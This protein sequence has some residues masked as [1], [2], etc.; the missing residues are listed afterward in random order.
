MIRSTARDATQPADADHPDG[1][2][3]GRTPVEVVVIANE[4]LPGRAKTRL[5]PPYTTTEAAALA[6]A[7][8]SDTL[9]AV[10]RTPGVRRAIAFAGTR[11]DWLPA[12]FTAIPQRGEGLDER[13]AAAFA[14]VHVRT[15]G[16]VVIIGMD[17]PQVT[18]ALLGDAA[19]RLAHGCADAVFGPADDGGYWLLGL[20]VPDPGFVR[21]VPMSRPDTGVAQLARL[22]DARLRV[23]RMPRLR[24]VDTYA[25]AVR[26]ARQAPH[27]EFAAR[28]RAIAADVQARLSQG[29][30]L[31]AAH[32]P[33]D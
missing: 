24:D 3:G 6:E 5:S 19:G 8:L 22:R 15:G 23:H 26:V 10:S 31:T 14:D 32:A 12:G 20:R 2:T 28:V 4:P 1:T 27:T 13:L 25:D 7:A 30:H 16:A 17:T 33:C 29:D 9:R 11:G 21:G 18:P